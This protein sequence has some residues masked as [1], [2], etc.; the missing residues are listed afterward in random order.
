MFHVI[1]NWVAQLYILCQPMQ[2]SLV[3]K[4]NGKKKENLT[5]FQIIDHIYIAGATISAPSILYFAL[6]WYFSI[7]A[8]RVTTKTDRKGFL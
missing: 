2:N 1:L 4:E 3:E 5:I 8:K 6:S 7:S